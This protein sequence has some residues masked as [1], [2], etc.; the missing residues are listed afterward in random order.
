MA[1]AANAAIWGAGWA[2][3]QL[4]AL[5]PIYEQ[6]YDRAEGMLTNK[7]FLPSA[8]YLKQYYNKSKYANLQGMNRSNALINKG[9][10]RAADEVR[11]GYGQGIDTL[12]QMYGQGAQQMQTGVNAWQDYLADANRGY[13]MYQNALGLGGAQGR[14]DAQAA[15]QAGPGYQWSVD[16]AAQQAQRAGNRTGQTFGGNTQSAIARQSQNLANQEWGNWVQNLQGFQGAAQ[17]APRATP[18][19]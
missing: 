19:N 1:S 9:M 8:N 10:R 6:G 12:N 13:D 16:Q 5:L 17:R 3:N 15:F 11:G 18:D 14:A 2:Q 7:G 4:K